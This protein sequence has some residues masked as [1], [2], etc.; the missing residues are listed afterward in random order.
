MKR[1]ILASLFC[2]SAPVLAWH[3]NGWVATFR[4]IPSELPAQTCS[5]SK[6]QGIDYKQARS[7]PSSP[8]SP[9]PMPKVPTIKSPE[10]L[11]K[12]LNPKGVAFTPRMFMPNSLPLQPLEG[13]PT[14]IARIGQVLRDADQGARIRLTFFGASHT[15]GD[16]WTGHI[17]RVF[18]ARYGDIGHGFTMPVALYSGSRGSDINICSSGE[19]IIDYVG[20]RGGH[21]DNFFGLGMAASSDDPTSFG[22]L[23][24]TN[25]N[26]IG[27]EVSKYEVLTLGRVG[28][29]SLLAQVDR[30][31]PILIPTHNE[32]LEV[33][34]TR[35]EVPL[36][37]HRLTLMPVGD[38]EVRIFGVSA[39]KDGP[40]ALI[41]A[42]GIRGRVARTWLKWNE[43]LF[44]QAL[45]ILNPNI[46]ILAYG[47]NEANDRDYEMKDYR[48]DLRSVLSKLRKAQP[49]VGCILVGPSDRGKETDKD[50]YKVWAKT[51]DVAN[52]QR[53]VA[54]EFNCVFWDWQQATGGEGSMIA[55]KYTSPPLASRDLIHFSAKGY[56][57]SA[58]RFIDALDDAALNYK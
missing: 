11:P 15:G 44:Q 32:S 14:D 18:Q 47:T 55:W 23:E 13:A 40:G 9:L 56:I 16:Y 57:H 26:P 41:D 1:I 48:N 24:T 49:E 54:P 34:H 46:V 35:L 53:E 12:I 38:G 36:D 3:S 2:C 25:K 43:T 30:N 19:W 4:S 37:S 22:W 45:H 5:E 10:S 6:N 50:T 42:I 8:P 31:A 51:K 33:L 21:E 39:E 17:R 28:G 20:K 27:R 58:E 29:G 52:V 7:T